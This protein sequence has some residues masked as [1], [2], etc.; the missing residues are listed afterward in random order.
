M[1]RSREI[2]VPKLEIKPLLLGVGIRPRAVEDIQSLVIKKTPSLYDL[3][4]ATTEFASH[5]GHSEDSFL[6]ASAQ[7]ESML[8]IEDIQP[9]IERGKEVILVMEKTKRDK[10]GVKSPVESI[11]VVAS[12]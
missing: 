9:V 7:A 3:T 11:S 6:R 10:A 2:P 12:L 1:R 5:R 8:K 4:N